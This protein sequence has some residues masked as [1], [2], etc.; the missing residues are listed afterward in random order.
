MFTN[1]NTIF[2]GKNLCNPAT[3]MYTFGRRVYPKR[4]TLHSRCSF[5]MHSLSIKP[6]NLPL[7]A[8]CSDSFKYNMISLMI[9][10]YLI[11]GSS[12]QTEQYNLPRSCLRNFF[13]LRKC[14]VFPRPASTENMWRM[15]ELTE[16]ELDSKFLEQANTFCHYVYNN[17]ETKTV[18]GAR[19]ITGTGVCLHRITCRKQVHK[20]IVIKLF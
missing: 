11:L 9:H 6:M 3:L 14:F 7:L 16:K 10:N 17:S 19:T 4:F 8:S 12:R 18:T 5:I 2:K 1:F 15:E 20:N 13:A